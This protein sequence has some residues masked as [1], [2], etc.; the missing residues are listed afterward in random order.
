MKKLFDKIAYLMI[1]MVGITL[2]LEAQTVPFTFSGT[3][4]VTFQMDSYGNLSSL[5]TYGT[6]T[7]SLTGAGTRMVWYPG[8]AAFRAGQVTGTA[9]D[10]TNIGTY[11]VALG[12]DTKASGSGS[13]AM[14]QSTVASGL[15]SVALGGYAD[16]TG[17]SSAAMG[18]GLATG[19]YSFASGSL[20]VAYG[21]G[22]VSFGTMSFATGDGSFVEGS[23]TSASG[24]N[25][26]AMGNS[27]TASGSAAVAFGSYTTATA[28][29]SFVI[30]Q[31]NVGGGSTS[32][33]VATDPILEV[34]IGTSS[35]AKSDALVVYKNGNMAVQGSITVG[36]ASGDIPM[37]TGN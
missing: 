24:T 26:I 9:W 36:Q 10:N 11:S 19:S 25:S 31:Y 6:G 18:D 12:Q 7:L 33:W 30:G 4:P 34:G 17:S 23:Y 32:T 28:D 29:E 14:G 1:L 27:T 2:P 35:S 15:D 20:S 13:T 22:A 5:G 16:A 3:S 21:W 8:K 37:Y